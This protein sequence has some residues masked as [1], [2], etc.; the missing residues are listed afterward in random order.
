MNNIIF[1]GYKDRLT[2]WF[3]NEQNFEQVKNDFS[4]KLKISQ[5]F[6]KALKKLQ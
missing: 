1:K 4:S 2:V 5:K 3:D 6:L